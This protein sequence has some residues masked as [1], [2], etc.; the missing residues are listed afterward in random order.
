M[1]EVRVEDN[2]LVR[3]VEWNVNFQKFEVSKVIVGTS[4]SDS[5][6]AATGF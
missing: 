4:P 2:G 3:V 1:E 6:C 5:A